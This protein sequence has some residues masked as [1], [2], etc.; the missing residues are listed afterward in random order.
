VAQWKR[1]TATR[2][3]PAVTSI[4][5]KILAVSGSLQAR[6]SNSAL[7]R[8]A[9]TLAN[10]QATVDVFDELAALP[11]FNPELDVEP[12][13]P[14]VASLRARIGAADGVLIASPE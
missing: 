6:S 12:A 3:V 14:A 11:Y 10:G 13:P 5:I 2:V 1:S 9:G 4:P 7:V 8:L